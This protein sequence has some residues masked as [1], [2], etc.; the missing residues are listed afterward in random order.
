MNKDLLSTPELAARYPRSAKYD[1]DWIIENH[2]GSH[3]LWLLESLS[4]AME[5]RPGMRV[6]DLGCGKAI[7]SIFLARE[8][9][10]QVWAAD[11][12]I[13][14]TDNWERI[15]A[16]GLQDQVF[17]VRV[18]ARQIPFA[19]GFFDALVGINSLQ[20]FGTDDY[21]LH[22]H[23]IGLVRPGGQIGMVVPGILHE[24]EGLVPETLQ[25]YWQPDYYSWHS[26]D[27][28]RAHW[29]RSGM[30][31][32]ETCD[33]FPDGEGYQIFRRFEQAIAGDPMVTLDQGRHISFVRMVVRRNPQPQP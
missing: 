13:A 15:R 33:T 18:E 28:W 6:L 19:E 5:L 24:F 16:A 23:L 11:L 22:R 4:T 31:D 1:L 17:P 30:V 3:C 7:S 25:R 10:V 26:P 21:Y 2:L 20:F 29:L 32:V 14:P 27:W 8:F 12:W 9:D